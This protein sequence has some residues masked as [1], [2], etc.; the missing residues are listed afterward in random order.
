[1]LRF[2]IFELDLHAGELRKRGV[3]QRLQGQPVQ[4][5]ARLVQSAGNLVTREELHRQLWPDDT[6]VDFDHG[7]HNAVARIREV[8]GDSAETPRFIET[9]PRRGYRFIAKVNVDDIR[10]ADS[11]PQPLPR[12]SLDDSRRIQALAVLPLDDLSGDPGQDYFADGMT[13]ALITTLAKIKSLRVISRTSA[14]QYKGIRKSLPQIARELN[15]D[16]VIEGSVLRSGDRIRITAQLIHAVSDQHLWAESYE[17]D[18]REILSL[19]SDIARQIAGEVKIALTPEERANLGITRQIHPEAHE[20]YLKARFHWNKRTE[21]SV[22]NALSYFHWAVECDPAYPQ[23]HAGIADS[24]AILGYYNALPPLEAYPKARDAAL[25]ALE[26][27]NSLAEPHATLGVIKRDFEWDWT[28]AEQEFQLAI[29]LNPGL[30][31]AYHW[32]GTLLSILGQHSEGLREKN[33]ALALDPLSV[34]IRTDMAR[35]LYFSRQYDQSLQLYRTALELDPN[36]SYAH[37]WLAHVYEQQG[38]SEDAL[39]ELKEGVR[40]S[41]GS[42]YALAKLGQGYAANGK[43]D[44][45]RA[46]LDQLHILSAQ[47]YVSPYDIAMIHLALCEHDQAFSCLDRAFEQRSLWLGYLNLEPQLDPLRSDPRFHDLQRRVGLPGQT[48]G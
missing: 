38:R 17:R 30:V 27:D 34:V 12:A 13:E 39:S 10:S 4:I 7:L 1:V 28:G 18:F 36:F 35:M 15:V 31:E 14:M 24:Y 46:L 25:K 23:G 5:L 16:A 9:L 43:A 32:R 20:F 21:D 22:K 3:K 40:L 37:L 2:D 29:Q 41:A 19:Q 47:K 48:P 11:T 44:D 6:F 42:T 8:L 26:L 45:A 33:K